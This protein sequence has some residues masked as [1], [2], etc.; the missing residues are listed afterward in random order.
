MRGSKRQRS[1][2]KWQL[3]VYVGTDP[4]TGAPRQVSRSFAG[5][6]R[7]ADKALRELIAEVE[8]GFHTPSTL[9]VSRHLDDW[10]A[11][12]AKVG[13][14]PATL[15]EYR[16]MTDD[17]VTPAMGAIL[18]RKLTAYDL[19]A[20]YGTLNGS[21]PQ[22]HSMMRAALN[23]AVKWGRVK[24]NV[25][26][27]A[28]APARHH[29]EVKAPSAS[30][31]AEILDRAEPLV[32][33]LITLAILTGAR[34]GELAALT[35]RDYD[36][37]T[38]TLTIQGAIVTDENGRQ[39]RKGTKT[40]ASRTVALG[41]MGCALL[42]RL[43]TQAS[44]IDPSAPILTRDGMPLNLQWMSEVVHLTA[45]RAG[46]DL[47]LH[48]LRHFAA[49][50]LVGSGVD[51][52]TVAARLGHADPSMTLRVYAHAT[53]RADEDAARVLGEALGG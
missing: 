36:R 18:L 42:D 40:H 4:Q 17:L 25:A 43:R 26:L 16:R 24:D 3:R 39:V 9:T 20:F 46:I 41:T 52:R 12:L 31:V 15:R 45:K 47:H 1:P 23:Q 13:R 35:W 22:V 8:S 2:R 27:R 34:R 6:S 32:A 29:R 11:H 37:S 51:V 38:G 7:D 33:D 10:L 50:H 30:E 28:T 5:N 19:D 48:S 14:S 53:Q 49:T 44:T 21:K